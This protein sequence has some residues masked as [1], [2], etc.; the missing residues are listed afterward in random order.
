MRPVSDTAKLIAFL[1]SPA[2]PDGTLPYH[3]LQGF[4]FAVCAAPDLVVPSEWM[5]MIFD[6][7]EPAYA[8]MAEARAI[9]SAIMALHGQITAAINDQAVGLPADCAFRTNALDNFA[10]EAPVSQWCQG[11]TMGHQWL[12]ESWDLLPQEL[13]E[14]MGSMLLTLG[15]F[16]SR[17]LG[18]AFWQE[19]QSRKSLREFADLMRDAFEEQMALYA[20]LGRAMAKVI[21]EAD[22]QS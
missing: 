22:G 19:T 16:A 17:E 12:E 4:L 6:Q 10:A 1:G 9:T 21:A 7:R 11:F 2:R 8:D 15:F 14:D 3:A 13:D 18:E 20:R 5:P